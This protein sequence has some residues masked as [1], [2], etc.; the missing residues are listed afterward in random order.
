M[1]DNHGE[2]RNSVVYEVPEP[3]FSYSAALRIFGDIKDLAAITQRLGLV[4]SHV[5][6]RGERPG[7]R[8]PEYKHDMWEYT[9]PVAEQEPL[10]VHIQSLWEAIISQV[11]YLKELK[12]QV[13]VDV[14]C[15]FRTNCRVSGLEIGH[16]SLVLFS[17]LE[18]PLGISITV[19]DADDF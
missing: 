13:T 9:A 16:E 17:E 14:F 4:P 2:A 12:K 19:I 18:I 8:S 5:H 3:E 10:H 1:N 11:G 7:P 6:K 15:G